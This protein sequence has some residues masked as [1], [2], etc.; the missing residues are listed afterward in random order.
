MRMTNEKTQNL[1]TSLSYI[2]EAGKENA[3]LILFPEIQLTPFFPQHSGRDVSGNLMTADGPEITALRNAC[4]EHCIAASPNIYLKENG[5]RY[6]A[7]F[8]IDEKGEILG[9]S[10][11]VHIATFPHF[12]EGEYY[13]PSDTGFRVYD[14]K[15]KGETY[16]IGIVICFDRHLPESIRSCTL[17]GADLILVSTANLSDEPREMFLWE[18]RVQAMQNSVNIAMCNRVG[19][20][21]AITFCG[22]SVL[23]D[24]KGNVAAMAQEDA[25][26]LTGELDLAG[27]AKKR[28]NFPYL[29]SRR[30]E[31][32]AALRS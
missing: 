13:D 26:L 8:L 9:I 29:T 12:Y 19:T 27:A 16:R 23:I 31:C 15:C 1:K 11:M 22:E 24:Y 7:S 14:L 3:D 5:H 32:Y 28:A 17:M 10:K 21:D 18:M 4:R 2:E 6:D 30:P 20:E 25:C